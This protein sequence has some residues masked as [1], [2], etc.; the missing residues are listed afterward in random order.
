MISSNNPICLDPLASA[1]M[2]QDCSFYPDCLEAAYNCGPTG[3]PLGYGNKYCNKFLDNYV[4]YDKDGQAWIDGTLLCLK[5]ALVPLVEDTTGQTCKTVNDF[6]FASH[7]GCYVNNGFCDL[8][9]NFGHPVSETRFIHDLMKTYE[10][11]D[12]AS[13]AAIKQIA[14][15][16]A[17]CTFKQTQ[18]LQ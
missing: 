18:L 6:A 17:A 3:Y 12:F 16:F 11:S 9:F 5:E 14:E 13:F 8:A 15:V 7:V 2:P 1:N 10:V 4:I